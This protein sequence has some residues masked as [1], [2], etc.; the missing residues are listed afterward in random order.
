MKKF[1]N[2]NFMLE[3]KT[4]Q[5]LY[6]DY[7]A[8]MPIIDYHCHLSAQEIA[9][10]KK[11]ENITQLWLKGDHYKWRAMRTYGVDEKYITGNASDWEK[12]QKWA[13]VVPYTVRNPLYHW[14]HL[15]LKRYFG[16][17]ELLNPKTAASIFEKA[18]AQLKAG[19]SV[20][21]LIKKM[22]VEIICTT[23]D[24][25]D[26]LEYHT[27]IKKENLKFKVFP[28]WRP[29]KAMA[30][31]NA[32]SYNKYIDQLSLSS[33]M[34][35]KSYDDLLAALNKR[36]EFFHQNGSRLSD[37][38]LETIYADDYT[39]AEVKDIFSKVREGK[40][41][42]KTEIIKFKSAM[43]YEFAIMDHNKGWAQQFH[44]GAMRNNNTRMF[45]NLGP[46]TGFDSIGDY[47]IGTSMSRLFDKLDKDDKL[48]KTVIYNLNPRDNAMYATMLG[49]FQGSNIHGKMQWGSGW[50]FLDQKYG[51]I[52]H[53]NTLS[54]LG[55]LS[56]FVGMLTDSRSF[57]SFP[58]HEYFRRILCN[59]I[60][61]DVENGEI[62]ADLDMLGKM[63]ED[64][65]Y[66]N[67]QRYFNFP[68]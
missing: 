14:T 7:S 20:R 3:T 11:F 16:I 61:N 17:D 5:K 54:M 27:S 47:E 32:E 65:S 53:L 15:E 26:S 30:V 29:D 45:N 2:K 68:E 41:L 62:P 67:A 60:G 12:F 35:I 66:Y 51:M 24:P 56:Q 59:L 10:D 43:L 19:Y 4:A 22:N 23:D 25:I 55:L 42:E 52:D 58:R 44:C 6:H 37:H 21:K 18:N 64:I 34:S 33:N 50:W 8:K 39:L 40:K 57:L 38:G 13:E 46:D 9:E 36:H 63:I 1:M 31:D 48:A 49:N 28:A